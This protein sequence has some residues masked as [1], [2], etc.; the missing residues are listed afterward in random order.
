MT[1]EELFKK[2][3]ETC[4]AQKNCS[5]CPM[6]GNKEV[7]EFIMEAITQIGEQ[8]QLIKS[9]IQTLSKTIEKPE[10]KAK[11]EHR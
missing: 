1:A 4:S 7:C 5:G 3:V 6:E 11:D 8:V 10:E 9:Y 2:W